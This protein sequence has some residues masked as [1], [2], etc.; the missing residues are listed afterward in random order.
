MTAIFKEDNTNLKVNYVQQTGND[1]LIW[2]SNTKKNDQYVF[3]INFSNDQINQNETV[4]L[5]NLL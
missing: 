2:I 4:H 1:Y 3:A 5:E